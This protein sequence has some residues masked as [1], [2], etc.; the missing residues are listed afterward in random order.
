MCASIDSYQRKRNTPTGFETEDA[1]FERMAGFVTLYA[2]FMQAD[3][4][5]GTP[6]T[7]LPAC[8]YTHTS[9]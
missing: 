8:V 1:F 6:S 9:R 7:C 4:F 5:Q 2:A 3:P